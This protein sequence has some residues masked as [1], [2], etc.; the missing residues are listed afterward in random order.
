MA[1]REQEWGFCGTGNIL[2]LEL[3]VEGMYVFSL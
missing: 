3:G 2:F 1:R